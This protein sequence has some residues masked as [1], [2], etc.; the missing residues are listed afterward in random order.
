MSYSWLV[1]TLEAIMFCWGEIQKQ[2]E[3]NQEANMCHVNACGNQNMKHMNTD[4]L[5]NYDI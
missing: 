5:Q 3:T 2:S 4:F 1:I